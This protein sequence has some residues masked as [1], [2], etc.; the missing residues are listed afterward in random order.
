MADMDMYSNILAFEGAP[1][2][3]V[4]DG[5]TKTANIDTAAGLSV[6]FVA[7][8]D[9]AKA[10]NAVS[11]VMEGSEDGTTWHPVPASSILKRLPANPAATS[12]VHLAGYIGKDRHVRAACDADVN[13]SVVVLIG[14]LWHGPAV[15]GFVED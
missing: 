10:H 4:L 14:N 15:A 5:T 1:P 3:S 2:A 6:T 11:W 8:L 7:H 13:G 9:T 12:K